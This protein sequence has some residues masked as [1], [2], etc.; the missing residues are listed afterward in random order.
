MVSASLEVGSPARLGPCWQLMEYHPCVCVLFAGLCITTAA[1]VI[2]AC[3]KVFL[4]MWGVSIWQSAPC[5]FAAQ[6]TCLLLVST[7]CKQSWLSS[8]DTA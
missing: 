7:C 6:L 1:G 8:R 2:M 5:T 3:N 4:N